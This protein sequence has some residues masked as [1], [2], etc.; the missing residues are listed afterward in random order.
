MRVKRALVWT[1][2]VLAAAALVHVAAVAVLPYAIM[3]VAMRRLA[4]ASAV[5]VWAHP[6]LATAESR[7]IVL[8]SP[9]LAYS[10]LVFDVRDA[11]LR[12]IVPLTAPYTSL[13]GFARNTDNFFAVNDRSAGAPEIDIVLV[14]PRTPRR[15]LDGLR[16]IESP[17]ERGILLVRRVV[18]DPAAFAAIDSVRRAAVARAVP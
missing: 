11:P 10:S 6:P 7:A 14:G 8:P 9:D 1:L 2:A 4:A 18:S 12:L 15:G 17:S 16:V 5:N 3:G 13:S